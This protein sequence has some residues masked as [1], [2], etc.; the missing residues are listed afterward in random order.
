MLLELLHQQK[1]ALIIDSIKS[2]DSTLVNEVIHEE[3]NVVVC[4]KTHP[5]INGQINT[6]QF[7]KEKH[8]VLTDEWAVNQTTN[9]NQYLN[10]VQVETVASS[11]SGVV[12]NV[13]ESD[14]IAIIPQSFAMKWKERLDLQVIDLPIES[15]LVTYHFIYHKRE[16][17][18][19]HHKRIR[20]NIKETLKP[21]YK[22]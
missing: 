5:R 13:I 11:L 1:I 19:L 12:L 8:C 14:N 16:K 3:P 4:R 17:N 21:F 2:D 18:N 9:H 7:F 10:N 6:K 22:S 15:N 20:N